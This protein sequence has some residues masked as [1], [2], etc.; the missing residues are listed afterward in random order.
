VFSNLYST[1]DG[2]QQYECDDTF[3]SSEV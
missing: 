1:P 3:K 2:L